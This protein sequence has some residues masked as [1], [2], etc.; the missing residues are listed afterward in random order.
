MIAIVDYGAGNLR[1]VTNSLRYV[2]AD[3]CVT[4]DPAKLAD[5]EK[6]VLPGVGAF[7]A[8]MEALR[9]SGFIDPIIR[10]ADA[11]KPLIGICLGMQYLFDESE[12]MG[13]HAGLGLLPGRVVKFADDDVPRIPH[14][15]WNQLHFQ[16]EHP[17]FAGMADG[18]YAYFVHS[19]YVAT[20]T[21]DVVLA[22]TDYGIQYA[23]IVGKDNIVGIQCHPEKSQAVGLCFLQNFMEWT[24]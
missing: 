24:P 15:G 22:K 5:A 9:K 23:S 19:Y 17:L 21:D 2:G 7:G 13:T 12:E 16:R 3:V 14:I 10:E 20:D 6:I 1:S 4:D 8:G 18:G 11:G